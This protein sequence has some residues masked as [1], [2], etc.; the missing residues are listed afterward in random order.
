MSQIT[1]ED[2]APLF[3][4]LI[5]LRHES[6]IEQFRFYP[7][8]WLT[9]TVGTKTGGF[10]GPLWYWELTKDGRLL[11]TGR[12]RLLWMVRDLYYEWT[13]VKCDGNMVTVVET[14]R[15]SKVYDIVP[16]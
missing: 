8:G 5:E 6:I 13:S 10:F 2:I 16:D 14:G 15:G 9:A 4:R 1:T 12:K 7:D 11:I 3:N